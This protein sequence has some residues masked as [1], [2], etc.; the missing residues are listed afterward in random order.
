MYFD[1]KKAAWICAL[2]IALILTAGNGF[3]LEKKPSGEA[4]KVTVRIVAV[5]KSGVGPLKV[6]FE[7]VVKNLQKPIKLRWFFG[8][9]DESTKTFPLPQKL[10]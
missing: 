9:G 3:C 6:R 8:D 1:P 7:P 10:Q 4:G 2:V 5:P